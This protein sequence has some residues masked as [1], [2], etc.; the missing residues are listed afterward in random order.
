MVSPEE[1]DKLQ[2]NKDVLNL[3]ASRLQEI[4]D[5]KFIEDET[6]MWKELGI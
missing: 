2:N 1:Y 4:S 5:D 3:I 6:E